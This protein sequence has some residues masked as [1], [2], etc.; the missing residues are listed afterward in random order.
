MKGDNAVIPKVIQ[1]YNQ[2]KWIK[3]NINKYNKIRGVKKIPPI[4]QNKT[5][6]QQSKADQMSNAI[7]SSR[8]K[9]R[10]KNFNSKTEFNSKNSSPKKF[11]TN[12]PLV[13]HAS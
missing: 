1:F 13:G 9:K 4:V 5:K 2:N 3:I 11:S 10:C 7:G 12:I 8:P 6:K